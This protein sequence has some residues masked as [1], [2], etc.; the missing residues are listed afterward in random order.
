MTSQLFHAIKKIFK[1][2]AGK[3]SGEIYP[4]EIFLDSRNLPQF[5][6]HQFEGRLERPLARRTFLFIGFAFFI[7]IIIFSIKLF[8]LQIRQGMTY[9]ARSEA[10]RLDR[11]TLFSDR[12]VVFDRNQIPLA[13]NEI[14]PDDSDFSLR[15]YISAQGL[16]SVLGFVKYPSK[17]SSGIYYREDYIGK[18]GVEKAYNEAL[19]GEKG[20]KL[21]EVDAHGRVQSESVQ[22]KPKA[23]QNLVLAVDSRLN[24]TLY[25]LIADLASK[26]GFTGGAGVIM[27]VKTGELVAKVSYPEF[28]SD[29]MT[30]GSN[31]E[32]INKYISDKNNPFLDRSVD[33]L[34]TPGSIVKPFISLAALS[35]NII[36]PEKKILS[37]GSISLPNPYRPGVFTVFKDWRE[38]GWV[39][40]RQ[41][42]AV[43]SDVYFYEVGGGFKDQKGLGILNIDKYMK[44]FG[45]GEPIDEPL[46][47]G[48]SGTIPTPAWKAEHFNGEAWT[49][50]DTYHTAIGQY[51]FL[52]SPMQVVRAVSA[53]ADNGIIHEPTIL[54]DGSSKTTSVS[55][56]KKYFDVVR[57]GMRLGVTDGIASALNV[58]YTTV[59]AKT[60]TAELG[61]AKQQVNSWVT[62]F[63]PYDNPEYAFAIIMERGPLHNTIGAVSVMRQLLDWMSIN[64][65]D[66]FKK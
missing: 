15:K 1:R 14:N 44:M 63:F 47:S 65:P 37:T 27:N 30:Q 17:D 57:E 38:H 19:S 21:V 62:G 16:S 58:S 40:M 55:I 53:I 43:S 49:I 52:V 26:V 36:D 45:F 7:I 32:T 24:T 51:G 46:L 11:T 12:G 29:V 4:D 61:V 10:N 33:G 31:R 34:Y 64:T 25:N 35:E 42:L 41:A 20:T 50:G 3:K 5:N 22:N 23:G 60:G 6:K 66:Y 2:S 13:W 18:D 48:M 9:A 56:D 54:K 39:D 59:A 28:S 8:S